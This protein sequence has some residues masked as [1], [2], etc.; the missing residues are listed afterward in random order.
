M[1]ASTDRILTTQ[2]G[3]LQRPADLCNS[4]HARWAKLGALVE[5]AER[6]SA[7]LWRRPA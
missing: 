1:K 4:L 6:A 5:G 3:G 7:R 2:V